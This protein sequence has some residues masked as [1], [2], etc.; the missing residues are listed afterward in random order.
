MKRKLI[1]TILGLGVIII[2]LSGCYWDSGNVS[3]ASPIESTYL[4]SPSA[5]IYSTL[6]PATTETQLYVTPYPSGSMEPIATSVTTTKASL[7]TLTKAVNNMSKI[8]KAVV[9]RNGDCALV[10][11][12]FDRNKYN[13]DLTDSLKEDIAEL[14]S[15]KDSSLNNITVTDNITYYYKIED[16]SKETDLTDYELQNK[17]DEIINLINNN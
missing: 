6:N 5:T 10:G 17:M 11:V 4:M 9:V 3:T 1:T 2:G 14:L 8:E 16:L 12:A 13:G 7:I 15:S